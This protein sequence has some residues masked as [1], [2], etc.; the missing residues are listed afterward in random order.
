MASSMALLT[1]MLRCMVGASAPS[2][3]N[4]FASGSMPASSNSVDS[5]T[6][7]HSAQETRPCSAWTLAW[8]G[9]LA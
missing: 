8:I 2:A 5:R 3:R 4:H 1:G 6:P 7:V 9:S